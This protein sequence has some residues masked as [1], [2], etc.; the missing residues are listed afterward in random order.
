MFSASEDY[1]LPEIWMFG[2]WLH[3][4]ACLESIRFD[5]AKVKI[6]CAIPSNNGTSLGKKL[7]I[8][9]ELI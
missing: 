5:V 2:V 3:T 6:L 8:V 7:H 4:A 9:L 1:S